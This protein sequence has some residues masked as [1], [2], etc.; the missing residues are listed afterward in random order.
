MAK[1][2]LISGKREERWKN[3]RLSFLDGIIEVGTEGT[4]P[5]V[6]MRVCDVAR[7]SKLI[8]LFNIFSKIV[9]NLVTLNMTGFNFSNAYS[10]FWFALMPA[11]QSTIALM[12][13]VD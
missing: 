11:H 9:N 7:Y 4:S 10:F 5:F 1:K 6:H 13:R 2:L 12:L 8:I 3:P